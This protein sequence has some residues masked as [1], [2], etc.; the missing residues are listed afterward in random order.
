MSKVATQNLVIHSL[1]YERTLGCFQDL[2]FIFEIQTEV[3]ICPLIKN[4]PQDVFLYALPKLSTKSVFGC[5]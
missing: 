4:D 3:L 2:N 1:S 5:A